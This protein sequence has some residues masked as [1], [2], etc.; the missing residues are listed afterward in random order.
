M[1]QIAEAIADNWFWSVMGAVAIT[2]IGFATVESIIKRLSRER[3]RREVAAYIAEGSM[4]A[5]QGE[6][7]LAA[8]E[9]ASEE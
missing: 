9:P 5:E 7:L 6:K 3:S 8:G 4:S 1:N 2:W